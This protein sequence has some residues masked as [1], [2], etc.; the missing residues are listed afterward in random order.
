MI[1]ADTTNVPLSI[2]K[3]D[4]YIIS[5]SCLIRYDEIYDVPFYT[6][7]HILLGSI[8]YDTIL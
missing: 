7:S 1:F 2:N 6:S 8:F 3:M 4:I 5:E